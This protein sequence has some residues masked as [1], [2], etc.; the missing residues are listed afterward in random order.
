MKKKY[1][2]NEDLV[3][4]KVNGELILLNYKTGKIHC[5][6][7]MAML[8]WK[9]LKKEKTVK[10]ICEYIFLSWD[11]SRIT[12]EKDIKEIIKEMKKESLVFVCC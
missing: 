4:E 12:L 5:L 11:C 10:E 7:E 3:W 9:F 1:I 8:V 6:N 2:R